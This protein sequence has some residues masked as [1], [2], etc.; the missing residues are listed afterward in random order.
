V[1]SS[2][3]CWNAFGHQVSNRLK[4]G[5]D[6]VHEQLGL[7]EGGE[8]TSFRDFSPSNDVFEA[9]LCPPSGQPPDIPRKGTE[10]ERHVY[11]TVS[12]ALR[13]FSQ[14]RRAD[15]AP[16]FG[17]QYSMMLSSISSNVKRSSGLPSLSVQSWSFS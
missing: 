1:H 15:E 5:S 9:S 3:F 11:R 2:A 10:R 6:L 12:G 17:S 8:V 13:A 16:A 7:L 14:Y 4:A